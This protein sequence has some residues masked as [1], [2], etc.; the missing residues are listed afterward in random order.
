LRFCQRPANRWTVR[1]ILNKVIPAF[2]TFLLFFYI[3]VTY[4][5]L[6]Y[7][8]CTPQPD[9][10]YT[11]D[12]S[13]E[14]TCYQ[15]EWLQYLGVAVYGLFVWALGIPAG[16]LIWMV[17]RKH[18]LYD[19]SSKGDEM[20]KWVGPIYLR[21]KAERYWWEFMNF[22]RKVGILV[23]GCYLSAYP[24]F[25]ACLAIAILGISIVL[26]MAIQPYE[27]QAS[28]FL[29]VLLNFILILFFLCGI[30]FQTGSLPVNNQY[31]Q[32]I[33]SLLVIFLAVGFGFSAFIF[34]W[35]LR[36]TSRKVSEEDID[37]METKLARHE[38]H[39]IHTQRVLAHDRDVPTLPDGGSL[40]QR[41]SSLEDD[42][43]LDGSRLSPLDGDNLSGDYSDDL[44][45]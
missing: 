3:Q 26:V 2:V 30:L 38:M 29:E 28:N 34:V 20:Y 15:A 19:I 13:G 44:S 18:K 11:L 23:V 27:F 5:S 12:A 6:Q 24:L 1:D 41:G 25:S 21:F 36:A 42:P 16:L 40:S 33:F 10:S 14:I 7:F 9:G 45:G 39:F 4:A 32:T 37:T 35:E 31:S 22:L 43:D 8:N 17:I